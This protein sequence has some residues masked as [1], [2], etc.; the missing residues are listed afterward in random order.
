MARPDQATDEIARSAIERHQSNPQD[1]RRVQYQALGSGLAMIRAM[2]EGE[3][4]AEKLADLARGRL[5][6]KYDELVESL[7]GKVSEHHQWLLKHMLKQVEF[8]DE[9]IAAYNSRIEELMRPFEK[10]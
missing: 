5:K 3:Q 4:E 2:S 9:E 10:A 6:S 7:E 8:L 1:A